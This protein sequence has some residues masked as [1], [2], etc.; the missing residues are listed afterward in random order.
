MSSVMSIIGKSIAG[1]E[2][3]Q[4]GGDGTVPVLSKRCTRMGM[5]AHA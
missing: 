1:K 4:D 3:A 2:L 5:K